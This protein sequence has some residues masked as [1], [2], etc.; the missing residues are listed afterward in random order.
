MYTSQ[1]DFILNNFCVEKNPDIYLL[2][3]KKIDLNNLV[4]LGPV[5]DV[6][7]MCGLSIKY[8]TGSFP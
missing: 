5:K 8:C 1:H 6:E 3:K 7:K 4:K 2:Q